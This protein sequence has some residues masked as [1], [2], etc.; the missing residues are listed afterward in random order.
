M[1]HQLIYDTVFLRPNSLS[2]SQYILLSN[3]NLY[4]F[5]KIVK[6]GCST[7]HVKY[8]G[9]MLI[10]YL[11]YNFLRHIEVPVYV[12]VFTHGSHS[13]SYYW[14]IVGGPNSSY[15]YIVTGPSN[16]YM[17]K[18]DPNNSPWCLWYR[19]HISSQWATLCVNNNDL[20]WK[21]W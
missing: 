9:R 12:R 15:I 13:N 17:S 19:G 7:I 6:I 20:M 1:L 11:I 10:Y 16:I 14:H 18:V 5:A 2:L 4:V 21:V 3:E 8:T